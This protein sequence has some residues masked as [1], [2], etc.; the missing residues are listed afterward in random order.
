MYP[1][2]ADRGDPNSPASDI[3]SQ[4]VPALRFTWPEV[5]KRP[6]TSDQAEHYAGTIGIL[7]TGSPVREVSQRG[8]RLY[9]HSNEVNF[10]STTFPVQVKSGVRSA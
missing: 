1:L 10:W 5:Y 8:D 4:G 6:M 2:E 9:R 3:A 7:K